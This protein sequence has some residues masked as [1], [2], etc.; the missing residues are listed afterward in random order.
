MYA[1][2]SISINQGVRQECFA[3]LHLFVLYTEMN[4]RSIDDREGIKMGG[5]C[6]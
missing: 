4:M 6:D 3:S 5:A 2:E 1:F